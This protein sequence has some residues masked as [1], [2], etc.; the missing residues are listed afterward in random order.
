MYIYIFFYCSHNSSPSSLASCKARLVKE[1]AE[2]VFSAGSEVYDKGST[3]RL[4][5][6]SG[7]YEL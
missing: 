2:M 5:Y 7:R 6:V 4:R 1:G 3:A